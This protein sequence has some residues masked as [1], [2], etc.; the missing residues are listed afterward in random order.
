MISR[1]TAYAL[2]FAILA[3]AAL[4][5]VTMA[6]AASAASFRPAATARAADV[7]PT[8]VQLPRIEVIGHRS[9]LAGR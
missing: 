5:S 1:R 6:A 4:A 8:V 7:E 2:I 9:S 3:T